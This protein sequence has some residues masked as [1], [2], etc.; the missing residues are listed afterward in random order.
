VAPMSSEDRKLVG[1][2]VRH[3]VAMAALI[4]SYLDHS[5]PCKT[6]G[7][8]PNGCKACI[9]DAQVEGAIRICEAHESQD[10]H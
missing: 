10:C 2:T 8:D 5:E 9:F 1:W 4:G 7:S 3:S 6:T